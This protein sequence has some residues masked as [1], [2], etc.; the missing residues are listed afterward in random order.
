MKAKS[1]LAYTERKPI[2]L[3]HWD[4]AQYFSPRDAHIISISNLIYYIDTLCRNFCTT[5]K[6]C[7]LAAWPNIAW[8]EG[9]EFADISPTKSDA[10]AQEGC[11]KP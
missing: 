3:G 5:R 10:K 2:S 8:K 4:T 1:L 7:C 6:K 9:A 11:V